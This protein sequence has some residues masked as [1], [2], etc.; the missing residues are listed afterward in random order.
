M[1]YF[2][3]VVCGLVLGVLFTLFILGGGRAHALPGA[4]VKPPDPAGDAPG[5]AVVTL[6]DKFFDA[7][8]GTIFRDLNAPSFPLQIG[9]NQAEQPG[10]LALFR[11]AAFQ[12]QCP[13]QVVLVQEGSNVHT[14]VRFNQGKIQ[15]P[16]AFSGSYSLLG[17]CLR[18][19]GWA[20]ASMDLSF[21]QGQ[22]TVYGRINVE[23]V[24][25]EGMAPVVSGL[26]TPL[27]QNSI[28]QRVNPIEVLRAQQLML[29][30]PVKNS[31]GTLKAQVRDVRAEVVEN[32]LRLHITY[33]FKAE[34][35][36]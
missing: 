2:I 14:G 24:N 1:K 25:L 30:V 28:N 27:V 23:Q 22:Q 4:P 35:A 8:L 32:A 33:D 18:F 12:E 34:R 16:L 29:T 36:Q 9:A 20:Q 3:A 15:A 5:T 7:V 26:V 17:S 31:N 6:D 11:N 10:G 21:D 13:S 19:K